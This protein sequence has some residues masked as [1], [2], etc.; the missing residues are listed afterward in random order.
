M[1][2]PHGA[3]RRELFTVREQRD[4]TGCIAAGR[5]D[6]MRVSLLAPFSSLADWALLQLSASA[7]CLV[8]P[9]SSA[10]K[11]KDPTR[12]PLGTSTHTQPK[13]TTARA[14]HGRCL[15]VGPRPGRR[16]PSGACSC[17]TSGPRPG[18]RFRGFSRWAAVTALHLLLCRGSCGALIRSL[19]MAF[20]AAGHIGQG[21]CCLAT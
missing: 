13:G 11:R 5:D 12:R 7:V 20:C 6:D 1:Q 17:F 2:R 9:R 19:C 16:N 8:Q 3:V 14:S 10:C 21:W 18:A 4:S 15:G